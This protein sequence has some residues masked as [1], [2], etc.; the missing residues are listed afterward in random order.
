MKEVIAFMH[1]EDYYTYKNSLNQG[2]N[3]NFLSDY[4]IKALETIIDTAVALL[5]PKAST[6]QLNP[7]QFFDKALEL[8]SDKRALQETNY[9]FKNVVTT[10]DN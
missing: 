1:V 8:L 4:N 10:L 9:D 2:Q 6:K 7:N 3:K 5:V